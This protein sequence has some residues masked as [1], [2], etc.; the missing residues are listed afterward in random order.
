MTK[1]VDIEFTIVIQPGTGKFEISEGTSAL[2]TGV[3]KQLENTELSCLPKIN[4][5]N[6]VL[7]DK[8]DFYKELR[9]RGY[10][11][12]GLFRSV[13]QANFDGSFGRIKFENWISFLEIGRA[14]V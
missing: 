13:Q 12:N 11:Y 1:E 8:K 5:K 3:I 2:V 9:L 6:M 7:L 14:H 10:H 4:D